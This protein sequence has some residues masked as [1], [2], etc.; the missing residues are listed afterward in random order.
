MKMS[1][2]TDSDSSIDSR[3]SDF[4]DGAETILKNAASETQKAG[5]GVHCSRSAT[6]QSHK[7]MC[8]GPGQS[9]GQG[10]PVYSCR[11]Y[12]YS[13]LSNLNRSPPDL[14]HFTDRYRMEPGEDGELCLKRKRSQYDWYNVNTPSFIF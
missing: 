5:K 13:E 2:D 7:D 9:H 1:S 6:P 4:N 14:E 8:P 11:C 3:P 12:A 10:G